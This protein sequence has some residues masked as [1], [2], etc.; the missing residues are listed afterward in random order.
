MDSVVKEYKS[1]KS[2]KPVGKC[3]YCGST[4]NL[5]NEHIVPRGL[6]GNSVL[7]KAS[8][9]KCAKIT[10][11]FERDVLK[12]LFLDAR[13]SLG[14]KTRN[15]EERPTFLNQTV[16]KDEK[17]VVLKLPPNEHFTTVCLLEYPLPAYI[18]GRIYKE[19]V[20]VMAYS[21]ISLNKSPDEIIK[22]YDISGIKHKSFLKNAYSFPRLI[23]KIAYA[24]T[25][26]QFGLDDLEESFLPKTITGE[27]KG[28]CKYVGTCTDKIMRTQN[29]LHDIMLSVT[30][31]R[32][33][34][35]R[36][37]LFSSTEAPEY[38]VIVGI[39]KEEGY[40]SFLLKGSQLSLVDCNK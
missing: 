8:C 18:D 12:N 34:V 20:E 2:Y 21:I 31:N 9:E 10:S 6:N 32:E 23:A 13:V 1:G 27:D 7:P 26:A 5:S 39:L 37:K 11:E 14:L 33:I 36:I 22:K 25:V 16:I 40:K 4:E 24:F 19:A 29:T 3:I 35:V 28:I 17:E 15:P 30:E 38:L